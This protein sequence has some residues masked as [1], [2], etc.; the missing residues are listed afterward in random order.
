MPVLKEELL[1]NAAVLKIEIATPRKYCCV[2]LVTLKKCKEVASPK[3]KLAWFLSIYD[4]MWEE[5]CL[6]EK[7]PKLD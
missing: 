3:T 7:N 5:K 1:K 2:E 6:F 4:F